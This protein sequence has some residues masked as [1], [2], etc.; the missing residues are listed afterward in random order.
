MG[1]TERRAPESAPRAS[2]RGFL[3]VAAVVG[4]HPARLRRPTRAH[5]PCHLVTV[6]RSTRLRKVTAAARGCAGRA[7]DGR[8]GT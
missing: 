8:T 6:L 4:G 3:A 1:R 2:V 7:L 5:L